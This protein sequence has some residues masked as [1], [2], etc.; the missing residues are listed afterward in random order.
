MARQ[1]TITL[2]EETAERLETEARRREQALD[3]L[4]SQFLRNEVERL[5]AFELR[6]PFARSRPGV[7]SFD[8]IARVLDEL[9]GPEWK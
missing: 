8:C 7:G 5:D 2:D 1:L 3:E 6:G 9:E 4:A